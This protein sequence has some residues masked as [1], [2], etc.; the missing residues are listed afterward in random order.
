MQTQRDTCVWSV[1]QVDLHQW[2]QTPESCAPFLW[3]KSKANQCLF[4]LNCFILWTNPLCFIQLCLMCLEQICFVQLCRVPWTKYTA[5]IYKIGN[6]I[7]VHTWLQDIEE[8]VSLGQLMG[9]GQISVLGV[10]WHDFLWCNYAL[11][12]AP[13][14]RQPDSSTPPDHTDW[15]SL[16]LR[17]TQR[18]AF[19]SHLNNTCENWL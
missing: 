12:N 2:S 7:L 5:H 19:S 1:L 18:P 16:W 11:V 14:K 3:N 8:N 9:P 15:Q 17:T 13:C 6:I 10:L 4:M